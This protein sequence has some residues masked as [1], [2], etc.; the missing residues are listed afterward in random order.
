MNFRN[1]NEALKISPIPRSSVSPIL[2]NPRYLVR[3][4]VSQ[5]LT[6]LHLLRHLATEEFRKFQNS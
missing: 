3:S 6:K 1:D 4:R 5:M 2:V